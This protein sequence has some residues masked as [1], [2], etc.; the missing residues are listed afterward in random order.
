MAS[1]MEPGLAGD[2]TSTLPVIAAT[3]ARLMF[4]LDT[5]TEISTNLAQ[6]SWVN[7]GVVTQPPPPCSRHLGQ[8]VYVRLCYALEIDFPNAQLL[9]PPPPC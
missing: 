5:T 6:S 8:V 2:G 3:P 1:S 4:P 9:L 7:Q